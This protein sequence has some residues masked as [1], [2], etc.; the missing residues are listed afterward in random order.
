MKDLTRFL[1]NLLVLLIIG[2]V[3]YLIYWLFFK[4][5]PEDQLLIDKTPIHIE[6]IR[7]IA[8]ISTVNYR[9]EVVMDSVIRYKGTT[10]WSWI[11]STE[12]YD[13][14]FNDNIK[15][16]LTLIVRGE[17]RFGVD[18]SEMNYKIRQTE[19]SIFIQLPKPK[20][21]DVVVSP[22]KTEIFQEQGKWTDRE[23]TTL[24]TK[25][26]VKLVANANRMVLDQKTEKNMRTLLHQMIRSDKKLIIGFDE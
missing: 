10:A 18:L 19:D 15:R 9:D 12:I 13:R 20:V 5:S 7:A 22:S 4:E 3:G 23:R 24:E 1:K 26:K 2:A 21:L 6:A 16:R 14:N 17:V 11:D 25:A 8:E